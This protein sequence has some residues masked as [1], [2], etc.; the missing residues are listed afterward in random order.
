VA[1]ELLQVI[2][3]I[4]P[5]N[6]QWCSL[7]FPDGAKE[8]TTEELD[9]LHKHFHTL[10]LKGKQPGRQQIADII[11]NEPRLQQRDCGLVYHKIRNLIVKNRKH[12][13]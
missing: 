4:V 11:E 9:A 8:W 7:F 13:S 1:I 10:I 2:S 3:C 5:K 12:F 6:F